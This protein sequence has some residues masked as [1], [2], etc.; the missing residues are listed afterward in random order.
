MR[1]TG[2]FSLADKILVLRVRSEDQQGQWPG[3]LLDR[4]DSGPLQTYLSQHLHL[5]GTPR[6][7]CLRREPGAVKDCISRL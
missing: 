7:D 4:Q 3:G 1:G 6:V 2:S 5:N